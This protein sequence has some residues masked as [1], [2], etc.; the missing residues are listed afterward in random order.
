M[1]SALK[2]K[3][4]LFKSVISMYI[5]LDVAKQCCIKRFSWNS[6]LNVCHFLELHFEALNK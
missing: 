1:P 4:A 5:Y 3:C 2:A 6:S